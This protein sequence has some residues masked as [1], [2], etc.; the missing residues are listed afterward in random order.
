MKDG[1]IPSEKGNHIQ[2][3]FDIFLAEVQ[4]GNFIGGPVERILR[5]M[6]G[7]AMTS[8][9]KANPAVAFR[10]LF[11]NLAFYPDKSNLWNPKNR[12]M[13]P[14]EM[15]FMETHV[16]QDSAL[17]AW[18]FTDSAF[19]NSV[20]G[21]RVL[22]TVANNVKF[23]PWS[24]R[25]NRMWAFWGKK[26][27]VERVM[28]S[29]ESMDVK[30]KKVK[31]DD[32]SIAHQKKALEVLS[33][34]GVDAFGN[35]LAK[36][37]VED[38]H[39]LYDR[40]QRSPAEMPPG[41]ARL[42]LNLFTFPRAYAERLVRSAQKIKESPASPEGFRAMKVA[43]SQLALGYL[44][45]EV[46]QMVTGRLD[47]PYNPLNIISFEAGGLAISSIATP[48]TVGNDILTA[49]FSGDPEMQ[50]AAMGR[51]SMNIPRLIDMYIPYYMLVL[52]SLESATDKSNLDRRTLRQIRSAFDSE[53][54]FRKQAYDIDRSW[55]EQWQ[56]A[57]FGAGVDRTIRQREAE[58]K[59]GK[60]SR[61]RS[62][63]RS[64]R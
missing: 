40:A 53:Y 6:Y 17:E 24:D 7:Q 38:V 9:I 60:R 63:E 56:H 35:Y 36:N 54:N 64:R 16:F 23:Y 25:L 2:E 46:Y 19:L 55:Y 61:T 15:G 20:P 49:A 27:A 8:V 21:F 13:T 44:T 51:L 28:T 33:N 30:L 1:T 48:S 29:G 37:L 59:K 3:S 52:N 18:M 39:F 11:Q 31:M 57:F 10:N 58:R 26:N 50:T 45:G 14:K 5:A 34:D 4:G 22:N 43:L 62:R 32:L 42:L 41:T 12:A 47:N